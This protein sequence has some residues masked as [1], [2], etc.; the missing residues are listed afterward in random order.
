VAELSQQDF[1]A[2]RN[3]KFKEIREELTN[4]K[5]INIHDSTKR[6]PHIVPKNILLKLQV[7]RRPEWKKAKN[8]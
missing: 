5:I 4:K 2:N 3:T 1:H 8:K 6:K 7:P